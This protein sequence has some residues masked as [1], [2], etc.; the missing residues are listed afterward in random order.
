MEGAVLITRAQKQGE[1]FAAD[2]RALGYKSLCAPM[3]T[4]VPHEWSAFD[5]GLDALVATSANAFLEPSQRYASL[6]GLPL[7]VVGAQTKAAALAVGFRDVVAVENNVNDLLETLSDKAFKLA[8][9]GYFRGADISVDIRAALGVQSINVQERICYTAQ[10][11]EEISADIIS[12]LGDGR[13]QAITFFSKRTAE[14]FFNLIAGR[15][16]VAG[17]SDIKYLCIGEEVLECVRVLSNAPAECVFA[18]RTPNKQ[19]MI[20]LIKEQCV[21]S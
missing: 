7:Y 15:T 20:D 2:V 9:I 10:G 14:I 4:I 12:G 21:P 3:F 5:A 17:L 18:A 19:G 8:N 1:A 11:V 6:Q 13:I 16:G